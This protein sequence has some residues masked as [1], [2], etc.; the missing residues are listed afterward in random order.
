V[1]R[2]LILIKVILGVIHAQQENLLQIMGQKDA[3]L[4]QLV[5]IQKQI[6]LLVQYVQQELILLIQAPLTVILAQ[7]DIIH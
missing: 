6:Q 2:V 7:L 1:I 5:L 3:N 4:A